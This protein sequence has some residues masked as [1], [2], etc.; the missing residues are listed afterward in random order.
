MKKQPALA[1]HDT[2]TRKDAIEKLQETLLQPRMPNNPLNLNP[3]P[4]PRMR[5]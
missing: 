1:A 3:G 5:I 4:A 2:N